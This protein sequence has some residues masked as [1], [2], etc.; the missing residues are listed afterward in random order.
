M[1]ERLSTRLG[2]TSRQ[3]AKKNNK[4][5]IHGSLSEAS[6]RMIRLLGQMGE[7]KLIVNYH[8]KRN[9]ICFVCLLIGVLGRV[10]CNG[11]FA[12]RNHIHMLVVPGTTDT[13]L[14]NF[15]TLSTKSWSASKVQGTKVLAVVI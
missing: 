4:A 9:H 1:I 8:T 11:H 2:L 14:W 12:P 7:K 13:I 6:V 10:D 15:G 5:I 3:I